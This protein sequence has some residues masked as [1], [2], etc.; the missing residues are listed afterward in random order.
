MAETVGWLTDKLLISELK[1][2]HMGRQLE[3]PDATPEHKALCLSRIA[4]LE[5]QKNDLKAELTRLFS[6]VAQGKAR[7]KIYRQFKMYNDPRFR[8][9]GQ[10]K[11]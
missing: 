1:I 3:R 7:I 10:K 2:H 5:E 4:V 9:G 6:D 8:G 11:P